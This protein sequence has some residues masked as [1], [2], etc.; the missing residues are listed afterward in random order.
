MRALFSSLDAL[1]FLPPVSQFIPA[2]LPSAPRVRGLTP[3]SAPD[4]DTGV[5]LQT[6]LEAL[7][8]NSTVLTT[9]APFDLLAFAEESG[10]EIRQRKD[11]AWLAVRGY[12]SRRKGPVD[13]DD[14]FGSAPNGFGGEMG[15]PGPTA[16]MAR[17]SLRAREG[18]VRIGLNEGETGQGKKPADSA[19]YDSVMLGAWELR[20]E[21]ADVLA[22]VARFAA[23]FSFVTQWH[24]ISASAPASDSLFAAV[25]RATSAHP[26][27]VWVFDRGWWEPSP[28][29]WR[30]VRRS[31]WDDV[32]LDDEFKQSLRDDYGGFLKGRKT[33]RRL[34]VPWKRGLIFLGPPGN[35]KTSALKA[36][37]GEVGVP[38]LYVRNIRSESTAGW[39]SLTS[40]LA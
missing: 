24:L 34:G 12:D 23:G 20:W 29:L 35:G 30:D 31:S 32:I 19:V 37:M 6:R 17:M 25:A 8:A 40:P 28:Q 3:V 11:L 7:Y 14:E 33:Y 2:P 15:A 27:V 10:V 38:S 1:I 26:D 16:Q 18:E 22:I 4:L 21:G 39:P 9:Q 13:Y 36:I 5:A